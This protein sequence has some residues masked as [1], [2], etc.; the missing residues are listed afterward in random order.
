M[1]NG[2]ESDVHQK[3]R[4]PSIDL[5]HIEKASGAKVGRKGEDTLSESYVTKIGDTTHE[6][7]KDLLG[8]I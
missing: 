3:I 2:G 6:D 4:V 1:L 8:L 5:S 7:F